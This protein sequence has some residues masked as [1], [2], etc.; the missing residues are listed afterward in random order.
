MTLLTAID[1]RISR[2]SYK[3]E[4]LRAEDA[5]A[6]QAAIVQ[7]NQKMPLIVGDGSAFAGFKKS[8]GMF[9]GVA[10]YIALVRD[11]NDPHSA[12]KLGYYGEEVVLAATARGLGTCWVA[13][14]Y[15]KASVAVPLAPNESIICTI[16]VGDVAEELTGKEKLLRKAT[17]SKSKAAEALFTADSAV[18]D[19]FLQGIAA[20]QKAPSA[21]NRQPVLF[22]YK[23]G[24]VTAVVSDYDS[25][26]M[27]IDLGIAKRHFALAAG[28][29]WGWG[30]G[31]AF[32]QSR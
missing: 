16:T 17:R 22:S 26:S 12:E 20:V 19:W 15:D 8:Y 28:G 31:A 32:T 29:A 14:S 18:P 3:P 21:R 25:A 11:A 30:N 2:R 9:K 6:L 1:T 23:N 27:A 24:A 4:P 7:T 10:N 5:Q 13:G